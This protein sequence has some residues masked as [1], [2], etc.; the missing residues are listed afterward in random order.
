MVLYLI[1][2]C[3][4]QKRLQDEVLLGLEGSFKR[5][6]HEHRATLSNSHFR[7]KKFDSTNVVLAS[8]VVSLS[9]NERRRL[10]RPG[11]QSHVSLNMVV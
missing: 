6:V 1:S 2:L 5:Q 3:S 10:N 7:I 8:T 9:Q 11:A 4:T